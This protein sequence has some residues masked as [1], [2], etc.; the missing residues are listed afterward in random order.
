[1]LTSVLQYSGR[2]ASHAAEEMGY[3]PVN[4]RSLNVLARRHIVH[5][6]KPILAILDNVVL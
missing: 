6:H 5:V 4:I 3:R 2:T 1:M